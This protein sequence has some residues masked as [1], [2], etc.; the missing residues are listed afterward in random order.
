MS[1]NTL[2]LFFRAATQYYITGRYAVL[3]RLGPV[4]GNLLHHAVEMYLKGSLSRTMPLDEVKTLRHNLPQI[5][6]VFKAQSE[7]A[8]LARFDS[9]VSSLDAFEELRYP[10]SALAE[11]M[12]LTMGLSRSTAAPSAEVGA[13]SI[14]SYELYV[15]DIDAL[16]TEIFKVASVNP[17]F[18]T[19][20]LSERARAHLKES[21]TQ[22][23]AG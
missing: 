3:A 23:W 13:R 5:W 18:F 20:G 14:P 4:A 6:R 1:S 10:N 16:V 21:N 12:E 15:Q 17:A 11:G 22:P 7:N 9:L 19:S 8:G 2:R